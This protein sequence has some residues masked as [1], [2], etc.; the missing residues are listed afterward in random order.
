M[1]FGGPI[2]YL[3]VYIIALFAFLVWFDS[4]SK[5]PRLMPSKKRSTSSDQTG[6]TA[7]DVLEEEQTVSGSSD[8]L[9][10]LHVSKKFKGSAIKAVDD[11]SF[12]VAHDTILAL[13]GPNGAGKTTTFNIIRELIWSGF[14]CAPC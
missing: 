9:R 5:F 1:K 12:G 11:V 13:L 2:T 8:P 3:I 6:E 7:N 14:T 4:G 10:V